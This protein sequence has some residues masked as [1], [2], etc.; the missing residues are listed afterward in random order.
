[1]EFAGHR[2]KL[3]ISVQ[4]YLEMARLTRDPEVVERATRIAVYARDDVATREAATL[5]VEIDP[6]NPDAHQVLAV[7]SVREGDIEQALDHLNIL[8]DNSEGKIDQ[9]L[10]MIAN[11]LGREE[12]QAAVLTVMERLMANRQEDAQ[13]LFAYSHVVARL[14]DLDKARELLERVLVLE[15]GDNNVALSYVSILQR[16]DKANEAIQWLEKNLDQQQDDFNLRLIYARMLADTK[17]FDAARREFELLATQAPNNAD[18]LYALGLLYLQASRMDESERYFTRLTNTSQHVDEAN[19]Y[20]GRI[21]EERNELEQAGSWYQGVQKGENYFDAQIRL[22]LILAKQDK[23]DDA[24]KHL[25][26]VRARTKREKSLLI[27]AEGELL[28]GQ[29][30]YEDAMTVYSNA[31]NENYDADILYSRAML[32]EKM[33]RLDILEQDLKQ[34]IEKEPD[35]AQALNAL[36]Y[37]LADRT[38]R[39][40]EAYEYIKRALDVSPNDFYILDSMGWVLYRLGR[41]D[42]AVVYLRRAM[43]LRQDPEIAAHLGEVLWVMGDKELAREV[44]ETA[45]KETPEDTRLL[46]VCNKFSN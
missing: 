23:I 32:A 2:G 12:D 36:G 13:A 7:I 11:M 3:D 45:L 22:S 9:K 46:D 15:P 40:H 28:T 39:Y 14:G 44:W 16:Q 42:E 19:Y 29:K 10:W 30:R 17:Q 38:E 20:L 33:D 8:L 4:N 18:V 43:A 31:L 6:N 27:Q 26:S 25:Q 24:R 1:A 35:N 5:W 41:L 37:T 21:A 34:I